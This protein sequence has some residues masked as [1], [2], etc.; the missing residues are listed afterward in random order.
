MQNNQHATTTN[1]E[2]DSNTYVLR[3]FI[4]GATPNSLRAVTNLREICE[5][6]LPG[7]YTLEIVDVYQQPAVAKQE[8]LIALPL[9]I[10]KFP[11]PERR[12]IGDLSDRQKVLNAL[13]LNG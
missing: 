2:E 12:M 8:Q 1:R 11:L 6:H 4:T 5:A 7:K 10:K 9:L 13:M 3:L